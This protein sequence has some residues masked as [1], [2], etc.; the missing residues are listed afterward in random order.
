MRLLSAIA[1]TVAAVLATMFWSCESGT[2]APQP[3]P[4]FD[5]GVGMN[6]HNPSPNDG[7]MPPG[8]VFLPSDAGFFPDAQLVPDSGFLPDAL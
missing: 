3:F 4:D 5:G 6:P 8:D 2:G 1:L 7:P